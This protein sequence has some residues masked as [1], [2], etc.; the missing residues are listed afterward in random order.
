MASKKPVLHARDHLPGGA[1]PLKIQL[2][3]SRYSNEVINDPGGLFLYWKLDELGDTTTTAADSSGNGRDGTYDPDTGTAIQ[4]GLTGLADG[5]SFRFTKSG[6]FGFNWDGGPN[7]AV[8]WSGAYTNATKISVEC[9][10]KTTQA[11]A[12]SPY[13]VNTGGGTTAAPLADIYLDSSTG[14][15]VFAVQSSGGAHTVTGATV[16]NDGVTHYVVGTYD[17]ADINLYVDGVLDATAAMALGLNGLGG[18]IVINACGRHIGSQIWDHGFTGTLDEWA[19]YRNVALTLSEVQTRYLIGQSVA[20]AGNPTGAAGGDLAGT[21]PDPTLAVIGS[22]TGPIGDTTHT[23]VV[24]IDTKGRVTALTSAAISGGGGAPSGPAGGDL[25]GTYPNPT[26]AASGPGAVG[27]LGDATHVAAVTTDAKGRVSALSSVAITFPTITDVS[28]TEAPGSDDTATGVHVALTAGESLAMGDPVY[29]KSDGKVWKGD[30]DTAG[31]FPAMGLATT[32]AAANASVTVL[33]LGIARHDAWSW[34]VG[35][36]V[37][38]STSSG[39]TQTQPSATDNAVQV[40][41]IATH[42]DRLF[43]NPQ[44]VYLTHI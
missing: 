15:A 22:A 23:P 18:S 9:W 13:F 36:L 42:A 37:Y 5:T 32:T 10:V 16:I 3:T 33:L 28:V 43:V 31:T 26:L 4:V 24:T 8:L 41:G 39:L 25:T 30:A 1:D 17:G 20:V 27:P 34:T 14:Q 11:A 38:L 40:I 44:L 29:F 12:S 7:A 21:Y 6:H 2:T 35:G 19:F